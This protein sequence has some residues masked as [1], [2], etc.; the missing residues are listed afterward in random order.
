MAEKKLSNYTAE[1]PE[2]AYLEDPAALPAAD[3]ERMLGVGVDTCEARRAGTFI[4]VDHSVVHRGAQ[5]DG[6]EIMGTAEA[7]A[8]YPWAGEYIWRALDAH[9][10][11]FTA[12]AADRSRDGYFIRALP[13]VRAVFPVQACLYL[14][15]ERLAQAVHNIV[16]VEEGAEL[17]ILSGCTSAPHVLTGLHLGISEFYVKKGGRLTFTMIHR[18]AEDIEVRPRTATVVEEGGVF[19]SNYVCLHPVR[20]LQTCP[21]AYLQG[22]GAVARFNTILVA[23]PGSFMD[24]GSR[25]F[26][27]GARTRAELIART[28]TTGGKIV[29]RGLLVGEKPGVRAHLECRGL[30]LAPEGYIRAIPELEARV[31]GAELSHEAAVGKIAPEEIEYLMARGLDEDEATAT[32]VRGFLNVRLEGL[33]PGLEAEIDRVLETGKAAAM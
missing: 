9:Q 1:A 33:P 12:Y 30:I 28:V 4:Q 11:E 25:V 2:H 15:R 10:D 32:I 5:Q 24:V 6:I 23:P 16:I 21:V 27:A 26:L 3:R 13:G 20:M 19:L 22:E 14:A 8:R 17:E 29:N 7:L 31:A 18:W